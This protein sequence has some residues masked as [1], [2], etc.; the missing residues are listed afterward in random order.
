MTNARL[1]YFAFQV[2]RKYF[3]ESLPDTATSFFFFVLHQ[4]LY[5]YT[6]F[7]QLFRI[8]FIIILFSLQILLQ[9]LLF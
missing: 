5:Q 9:I 1:F 3:R 2:L 7:L 4:L 8:S 6:A